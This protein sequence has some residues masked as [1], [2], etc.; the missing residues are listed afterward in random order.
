MRMSEL[1]KLF[2]TKMVPEDVKKKQLI[3]KKVLLI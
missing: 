3:E 2:C 1:G